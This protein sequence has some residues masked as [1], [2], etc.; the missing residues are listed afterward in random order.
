MKYQMPSADLLF[1]MSARAYHTICWMPFSAE[2]ASFKEVHMSSKRGQ[3]HVG[4]SPIS[5][6]EVREF[7][8]VTVPKRPNGCALAMQHDQ[9]LYEK[10]WPF[11]S[12]HWMEMM[13]QKLMSLCLKHF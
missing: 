10:V 1:F 8:N 5:M 7:P 4:L 2:V 12:Q 13:L 6:D 11:S 3:S 9:W